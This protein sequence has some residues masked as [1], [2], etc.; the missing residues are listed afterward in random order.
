MFDHEVRESTLRRDQPVG[1]E[2]L[3]EG[4]QRSSNEPQQKKYDAEARNDTWSIEGDFID[5]HHVEPRVRLFVPKEES[6]P[7]PL[8]Y[9]DVT[10]KTHATLDVMQQKCINDH[11]NDD[12][13]RTLSHSW[14][15]FKKFTSLNE[16][17][18][19]GFLWSAGA[20]D[21]DPSNHQT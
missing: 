11:W 13:D 7:V 3:G 12:G 6:F 20:P 16:K 21:E 19:P 10:R 4:F 18:P 2:H 15:G 5:R 17:P 1:S 14:A 9:V 8:K